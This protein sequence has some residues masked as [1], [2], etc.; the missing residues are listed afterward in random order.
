MLLIDIYFQVM[1]S[2]HCIAAFIEQNCT[3]APKFHTI[4][5]LV[6]NFV[7]YNKEDV[8]RAS[9]VMSSANKLYPNMRII[10]AIPDHLKLDSNSF[11]HTSLYSYSKT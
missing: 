8:V 10:A 5:T 9:D 3:Y 6:F 4:L 7:H 2:L 1:V 11:Q